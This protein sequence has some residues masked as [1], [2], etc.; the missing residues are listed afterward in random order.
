MRPGLLRTLATFAIAASLV[1]CSSDPAT[2]PSSPAATAPGFSFSDGTHNGNQHF[3]FLP[4]LVQQP[5]FSGVVDGSRQPVV[6]ILENG[7][8]IASLTATRSDDGQ[9]YQTD[10]HTE[11]FNLDPAKTYRL[12]VAVDGVVLGFA[13]VD[14]VSNGSELK[15]VNTN[16]FVPLKDGRTLPIKF[17]IESGALDCNCWTFAPD[18]PTPRSGLAAAAL[19]GIVYALGGIGSTGPPLATVESFNIAAD[20]WSTRASM[21]TA[22]V[23]F[24]AVGVNG[25]IYAI[26]GDNL[27]GCG[28][29]SSK[30]NVVEAYDPLANTWSTLAPMPT[31]R[32]HLGVA[33]IGDV[34]YAVGGYLWT[35][36]PLVFQATNVVEAYDTRTNTWS[37]KAPLPFPQTG[38]GL[39][40][41]D[42]ILYSI[43]GF[44][45]GSSSSS[46][47]FA[48]DPTTDAW[49]EKAPMAS[50]RQ[51]FVAQ[52]IDG[53]VYAPGGISLCCVWSTMEAY[54]LAAN[55]WTF[56][57]PMHV[58][59]GGFGG[60]AV[61]RRLYVVGG[62]PGISSVE[63]YRP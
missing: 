43:G 6:Q 55:S 62:Y 17:R 23:D 16:E 31:T 58:N 21:P 26:G 53:I 4:P 27:N 50:F 49:T 52:S 19:N 45:D 40:V 24:G 48:Y 34:I 44:T 47:V 60:V 57:P 38:Q 61:N 1:S 51:S 30:L 46:P 8:R 5:T 11:L 59:R 63:F 56:K 35:G 39:A 14:V 10:W 42:G 32:A 13:D 33:A 3:Y 15:N 41:M 12:N 29:A 28:C 22:R 54:D 25:R 9:F 20:N 18:M 7:S 2:A 37:S 36:G